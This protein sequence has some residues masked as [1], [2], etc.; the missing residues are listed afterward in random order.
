MPAARQLMGD[1]QSSA[2]ARRSDRWKL[3]EIN[4]RWQRV[5]TTGLGLN[6]RVPRT[7]T[8][9][10]GAVAVRK[11]QERDRGKTAT[12]F[13]WGSNP[14]EPP[15][16][17]AAATSR[18]RAPVPERQA[19][20]NAGRQCIQRLEPEAQWSSKVKMKARLASPSATFLGFIFLG[21]RLSLRRGLAWLLLV[22]CGLG[23][24]HLL[25]V[26]ERIR[27]IDDQAVCRR[28]ATENFQRRAVIASYINV[29]QLDPIVRTDHRNL[30]TL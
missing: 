6:G 25:A 9:W 24:I 4:P 2:R 8:G 16:A 10:L 15:L 11:R 29:P 26:F 21:L 1:C 18:H 14:W 19:G 12:T 20:C 7:E 23:H 22:L 17:T 28:D 27:R 3:A 13:P 5:L 30:R